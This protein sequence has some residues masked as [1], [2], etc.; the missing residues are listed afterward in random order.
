M[1][2]DTPNLRLYGGFRALP[3]GM[4]MNTDPSL[5]SDSQYAFASNISI[6]GDLPGTRSPWLSIP[7]DTELSGLM[8]GAA[9]YET[10]DQQAIILVVGG[11]LY[12]IEIT[13]QDTGLVT[14]V[15]PKFVV[16][17]TAA[18]TVPAPAASVVISVSTELP[19]AN[20]DTL[21]IDSGQYTVIN[22]SV[23][24]LTLTYIATAANAVVP[25]GSTVHD[26]SGDPVIFY[27][28]LPATL[29][30]AHIFQ[31]ENYM[32]VLGFQQKPIIYDGVS[33]R[34]AGPYELPSGVLG[35]Y[36][37]G[38]IWIARPDFRTFVAGDLAYSITGTTADILGFTENTFLNEGGFFAVPNNGGSITSMLALATIDTSLGIGPILIGTT[39]SV[40][41]VN[42]PVDRTTWKNLTYPIQT[43][44]LL[45]Y[46]PLGPYST[47]PINNDMW[48]RS[49]DGL[50]SFI[51]ARRNMLQLGNTPLSHEISPVLDND[52]QRYLFHS[53]SILF[54]N[55]LF[56]TVAPRQTTS[57]IV[58]DGLAVCNFD[59]LS[60]LGAKQPA[61]WESFNCGLSILQLV[62]GR[63]AGTERAFI[64]ALNEDTSKIELW[65][66][67]P[68]NTGYYDTF[69]SVSR[70]H[71]TIVRTP[72][73]PVLETKRYGLDTLI[74][75]VMAEIY[76]DQ[77]VDEITLTI[78]F[79]PDE[80][81]AWVTWTTLTICASVTQCTLPAPGQFSCTIWKPDARQYAARIRLPRPPETC[82]TIAGTPVDLGYEF[83]FRF[84]GTGH[85]RLR[86]FKPHFKRQ[87]D[88]MEGQCPE[89][90]ICTAFEYCNPELFD[91]Q[92]AR[93]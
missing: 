72:I 37:W 57:G 75:L 29:D 51:I 17:T 46:G 45:D 56:A 60:T 90:S 7:L 28:S 88:A 80:Y 4:D 79:R 54:D 3:G 65:E 82:N 30:F 18:F 87:S 38:R 32:I 78:K 76:L 89:E 5:L 41:S 6:R 20:G 35:L 27:Q 86:K 13:P 19:F 33:S 70:G 73:K 64:I 66:M 50:R 10:P 58:H 25:T 52:T 85:F 91:Y 12:R 47:I 15:T 77:I 48:F 34:L 21:F 68:E 11:H 36:A 74:K 53:S 22:R 9:F 71:T 14:D 61:V 23:N 84:E 92:I 49:L 40:I 81:P 39:N 43:I 31:A 59:P 63:V 24:Q 42:A 16:L 67:Q 2:L 83:Q 93:A 44:S 69:R 1:P 62:R 55:R 8:P 26:A